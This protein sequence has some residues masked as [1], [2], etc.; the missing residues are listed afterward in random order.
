M[1]VY[2]YIDC[3]RFRE[4]KSRKR[5]RETRVETET[6]GFRLVQRMQYVAAVGLIDLGLI[7]S[8]TY[9]PLEEGAQLCP[10]LTFLPFMPVMP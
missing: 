5:P 1:R 9:L 3:V 8:T 6:K 2:P 7:N 4:T 10:L